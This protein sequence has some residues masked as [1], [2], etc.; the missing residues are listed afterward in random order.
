VAWRHSFKKKSQFA[1]PYGHCTILLK[2]YISH[3][4]PHPSQFHSQ[5]CLQHSAIALKIHGNSLVVFLKEIRPIH[6][7][8][9]NTTPNSY[10][11]TMDSFLI[12]QQRTDIAPMPEILS[13]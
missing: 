8:H 11:V 10:L 2:P 1:L 12:E 6:T 13:T 7:K 3:H 9:G 5:Q 4:L